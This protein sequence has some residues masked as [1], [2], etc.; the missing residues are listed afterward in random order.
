MR[1]DSACAARVDCRAGSGSASVYERQLTRLRAEHTHA[2]RSGR[3][4]MWL[5]L[6]DPITVPT[7]SDVYETRVRTLEYHAQGS[8][9]LSIIIHKRDTGS[10]APLR[11]RAVRKAHATL[12]SRVPVSICGESMVS[13]CSAVNRF[14]QCKPTPE[15]CKPGAVP[16][17]SKGD[18][19]GL[20][21]RLVRSRA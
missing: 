16:W 15:S 12:F 13:P 1:R 5:V 4:A 17:T 11:H 18:R 6:V 8:L 10:S 19:S 7:W 9:S 21:P 20:P 14:P 2:I 3:M